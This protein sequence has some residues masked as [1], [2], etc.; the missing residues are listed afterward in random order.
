[1]GRVLGC[2]TLR[3]SLHAPG[4]Q[5]EQ[6]NLHRESESYRLDRQLFEGEGPD[7]DKSGLD[8]ADIHQLALQR[9]A[10]LQQTVQ[11]DQL[12]FSRPA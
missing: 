11:I 3:N 2:H 8:L 7:G 6:R 9:L 5:E 10:A 4:G 12:P 1:M